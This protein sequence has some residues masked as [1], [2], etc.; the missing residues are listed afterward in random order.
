VLLSRDE[1]RRRLNSLDFHLWIKP[2]NQSVST[3]MRV[4]PASMSFSNAFSRELEN[5]APAIPVSSVLVF[6][7]VPFQIANDRFCMVG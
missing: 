6:F 3:M 4:L 2:L 5:A 1:R 7:A